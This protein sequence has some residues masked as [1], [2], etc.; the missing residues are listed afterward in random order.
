M[1]LRLSVSLSCIDSYKPHSY[2]LSLIFNLTKTTADKYITTIDLQMINI[3][4]FSYYNYI[5]MEHL[6][7][8]QT[9]LQPLF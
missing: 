7:F 8:P 1:L 3:I 9:E 2:I 4:Y 6:Y 5:T